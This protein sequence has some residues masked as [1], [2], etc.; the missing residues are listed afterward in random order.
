[1]KR[2]V[3]RH[4]VEQPLDPFYRIIPLTKEQNAFVSTHRYNEISKFNWI[5]SWDKRANTFY[6]SRRQTIDG[7][8]EHILMHRYIAGDDSP[9]VDH[10]DKNGLNNRDENLRKCD[11]SQNGGNRKLNSNNTSGYKGVSWHKKCKKWQAKIFVR[12][13]LKSLG[14][15][16]DPIDGAKA[17]DRAAIKYF[18]EFASLNFPLS[19]YAD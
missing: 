9:H 14:M 13:K 4:D 6:A 16:I 3:K 2:T 19:S 10:W 11:A 12:G 1:M 15:F 8:F 7:K 17:Y 5:A 18:G